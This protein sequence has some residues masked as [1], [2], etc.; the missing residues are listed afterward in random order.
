MTIL[1]KDAG[2]A[3]LIGRAWVDGKVP[4]PSPV[5]VRGE[6]LLDLSS[7]APTVSQLLELER[8]PA[9]LSSEFSGGRQPSLGSLARPGRSAGGQGERRDLRDEPARARDRGA[10]ARDPKRALAIRGRVDELVGGDLSR[11]KP[12]S[13]EAMALKKLLME[14]NA[15]S[16]YLEVGIGPDAEIFTKC[17]PMADRTGRRHRRPARFHLE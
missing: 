7:L 5:L 11:I 13:S 6:D 4:G 16:Q 9:R 3:L 12:G 14:Q 17:P 10:G 2:E 8:L 1:P 15:W